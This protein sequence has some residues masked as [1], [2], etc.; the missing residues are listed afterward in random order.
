MYKELIKKY[1]KNITTE[2]VKEYALK[3]GVNVKDEEANLFIN[4]LNTRLDEMLN[5]NAL[6]VLNEYKDK[7]SESSYNK[8]L[9]LYD[10]Y[11]KF[12]D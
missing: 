12:I 10:K 5:G 2:Q 1:A 9:E 8:L 11:K 3:E 7:I 6:N 4:I